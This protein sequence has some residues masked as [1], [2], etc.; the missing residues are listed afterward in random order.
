MA[1]IDKWLAPRV[2]PDPT[3]AEY[4]DTL[5]QF[6]TCLLKDLEL[7]GL[8]IRSWPVIADHNTSKEFIKEGHST[9]L[10]PVTPPLL[11]TSPTC[12]KVAIDSPI[13][14]GNAGSFVTE[15][16]SQHWLSIPPPAELA[17]EEEQS[18]HFRSDED[19]DPTHQSSNTSIRSSQKVPL[20]FDQIAAQRESGMTLME[21]WKRYCSGANGNPAYARAR[22]YQLVK[23]NNS[24]IFAGSV[25]IRL[26]QEHVK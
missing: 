20:D 6:A 17:F 18:T 3:D 9:P 8:R 7:S 1:H 5:K 26:R 24:S 4:A 22:F 2:W 19:F 23:D 21:C 14:V 13:Q 10:L 15:H 12:E 11:S 25:A 16:K